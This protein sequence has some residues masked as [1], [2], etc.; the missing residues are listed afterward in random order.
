MNNFHWL[1]KI[2]IYEVVFYYFLYLNLYTGRIIVLSVIN[3]TKY[4]IIGYLYVLLYH[5]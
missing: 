5:L 1:N 4:S 2:V 3:I